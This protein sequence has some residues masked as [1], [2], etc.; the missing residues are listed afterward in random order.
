MNPIGLGRGKL[1][2]QIPKCG[3]PIRASCRSQ[4]DR[5]RECARSSLRT[6]NNGTC[7]RNTAG[8][9]EQN[10]AR[11][12]CAS[13]ENSS[14]GQGRVFALRQGNGRPRRN[15]GED[16]LPRGSFPER[17]PAGAKTNDRARVERRASSRAS[18]YFH[19]RK[20]PPIS[21]FSHPR[22]LID[23][24]SWEDTCH[25]F[26]AGQNR[27]RAALRL[28]ARAPVRASSVGA[29]KSSAERPS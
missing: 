7:N 16:P 3:P 23:S 19:A 13:S 26:L 6:T 28:D 5:R 14:E 29:P 2:F 12:A 27:G 25:C 20:G 15:G 21:T 1:C 10:H 11:A 9:G 24:F 22:A 17:W 18:F 4:S 8:S